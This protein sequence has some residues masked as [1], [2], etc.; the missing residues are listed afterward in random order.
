M[1]GYDVKFQIAE[2][3]S[4]N[5]DALIEKAEKKH[6]RCPAPLKSALSRAFWAYYAP[7]SHWDS[8]LETFRVMDNAVYYV[9]EWR[10]QRTFIRNFSLRTVMTKLGKAGC[11]RLDKWMKCKAK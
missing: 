10:F 8:C 1:T 7:P 4:M 2:L 9:R 5:F 3:L 6:G 11:V